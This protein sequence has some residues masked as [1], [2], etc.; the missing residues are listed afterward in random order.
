MD[1]RDKEW[2][3]REEARFAALAEELT[4]VVQTT[5]KW[6]PEGKL[7]ALDV[8][9]VAVPPWQNKYRDPSNNRT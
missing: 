9:I 6:T 3:E 8:R 5:R 4:A 7:Q 2:L 1:A